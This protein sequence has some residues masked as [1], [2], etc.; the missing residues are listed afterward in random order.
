MSVKALF[1]FSSSSSSLFLLRPFVPFSY[2]ASAVI[3]SAHCI[4]KSQRCVRSNS[5]QV[6]K[7]ERKKQSQPL[8][9]FFFYC[10]YLHISHL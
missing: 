2:V 3:H 7:K 1:L 10:L 9:S 4:F 5:S 6:K 8:V